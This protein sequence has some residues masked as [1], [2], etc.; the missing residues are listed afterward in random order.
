MLEK[1][2]KVIRLNDLSKI[3]EEDFSESWVC[4]QILSPDEKRQCINHSLL[5]DELVLTFCDITEEEL[6]IPQFSIFKD[7]LFNNQHSKLINKFIEKNKNYNTFVVS[8]YG[9]VSRS[10]A[11]GN[12]IIQKLG[13]KQP[14]FQPPE[15]QPNPYVVSILQKELNKN[16][17][18]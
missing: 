4:L 7:F 2:V 15:K 18:Y 8:C 17:L 3:K 12:F 6:K 10:P 13:V 1:Q 14:L 16:E 11:V 9:G 5:K